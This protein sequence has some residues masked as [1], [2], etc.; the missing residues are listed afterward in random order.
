MHAYVQQQLE[1]GRL[2]RLLEF[3]ERL[4]KLLEVRE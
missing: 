4:D 1:Y 2:W 3:S